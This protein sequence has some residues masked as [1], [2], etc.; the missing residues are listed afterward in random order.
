[1]T[2]PSPLNTGYHSALAYIRKNHLKWSLIFAARKKFEPLGGLFRLKIGMRDHLHGKDA[3]TSQ[4]SNFLIFWSFLS[5]FVQNF[6]YFLKIQDKN[7]Q[8]RPKNQKIRNL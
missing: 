4:I 1:M 7:A 6:G 5:I 2:P 3:A 8:K